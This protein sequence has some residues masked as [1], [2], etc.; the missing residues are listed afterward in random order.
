MLKISKED[1]MEELTAELMG[2]E[3]IPQEYVED[4]RNRLEKYFEQRKGKKNRINYTT[5]S[6]TIKLKDETEIF[7]IADIYYTAVVNEEIDEYW[8]NFDI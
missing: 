7:A 2:Y 3:E 8:L 4:F 1:L 6:I 5:N